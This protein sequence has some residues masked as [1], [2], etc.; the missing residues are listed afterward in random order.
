MNAPGL[1]ISF[2]PETWGA[3]AEVLEAGC[4]KLRSSNHPIRPELL[5]R[6]ETVRRLTRAQRLASPL[7]R[8]ASS[9]KTSEQGFTEDACQERGSGRTL[10]AQEVADRAG[11][12][13]HRVRQL[14]RAGAIGR[15]GVDGLWEFSEEAIE[16]LQAR[17]DRDS[18][19]G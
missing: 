12:S 1:A 14:A 19:A 3:L 6:V 8:S 17:G 18:R 10:S 9:R 15:R 11:I 13:A 7:P 2:P 16:W 4:L 5:S